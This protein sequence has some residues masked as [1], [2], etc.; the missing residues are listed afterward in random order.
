MSEISGC[1]SG[2]C[3]LVMKIDGT[4]V[5]IIW[6]QSIFSEDLRLQAHG[7]SYNSDKYLNCKFPLQTEFNYSSPYW[8]NRK[9]YAVED[10]LKGWTDKQ[11]KTSFLLERQFDQICLGMKVNNVTNWIVIKHHA[12]SLFD[13]IADGVFKNKIVGRDKW[14][15]VMD[16]SHLQR[17]LW[18]TR[19]QY[20]HCGKK[21]CTTESTNRNNSRWPEQLQEL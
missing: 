13:V 21:T 19:V 5:K 10:G 18:Y 14:L 17:K 4:K 12:S 2:G 20:K 15:C 3:T 11:N 7:K 16:G 6:Y 9:T 1:G 8:T